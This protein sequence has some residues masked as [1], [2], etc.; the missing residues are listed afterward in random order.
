MEDVGSTQCGAEEEQ[1]AL[2]PH[3]RSGSRVSPVPTLAV[4]L[5]CPAF[6]EVYIRSEAA[7]AATDAE[8]TGAIAFGGGT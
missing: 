2:L 3:E 8:A 6:S 4:T 5:H 1:R 7:K